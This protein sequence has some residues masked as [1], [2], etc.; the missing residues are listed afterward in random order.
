MLYCQIPR[1]DALIGLF[2]LLPVF[3]LLLLEA[4]LLRRRTV[5]VPLLQLADIGPEPRIRRTQ[6]PL[7]STHVVF[8]LVQRHGKPC[9]LVVLGGISGPRFRL[10]QRHR[11]GNVDRV[12]G[13]AL[14][15]VPSVGRFR[16]VVRLK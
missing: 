1:K 2:T 5:H 13:V 3:A 4:R 6:W 7:R 16:R 10:P 9:E 11:V 12:G 14:G 15:D 8:H